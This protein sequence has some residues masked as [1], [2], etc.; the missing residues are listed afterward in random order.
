V[1]LDFRFRSYRGAHAELRWE[2]PKRAIFRRTLPRFKACRKPSTASLAITSAVHGPELIALRE[3]LLRARQGT[4]D[5]LKDLDFPAIPSRGQILVEATKRFVCS[6]SLEEIGAY[7]LS[8][9][10][11]RALSGVR[12]SQCD[13]S[14]TGEGNLH[15]GRPVEGLSAAGAF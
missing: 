5:A 8:R 2:I 1:A 4:G 3:A 13:G 7:A 10:D 14:R 12:F 6:V 9:V 15:N 11:Q